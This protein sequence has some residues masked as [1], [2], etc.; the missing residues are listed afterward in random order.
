[1]RFLKIVAIAAGIVMAGQ[2]PALAQRAQNG[3]VIVMDYERVLTT[4]VAGRDVE[5]KL[6]QIAEQMQA[7]LQP[8]QTAV[9]T[10]AQALQTATRG[11]T[12]EQIQR[13]SSLNQRVQ[14]F[15]TRAEAFR[16]QQVTRARDLEYT[17]QQALIEFNRQVEPIVMEVMNARRAGVVVDRSSVQIMAEGVDATADIISRLDQRVRTINVTR[18]SAPAPQQQQPAAPAAN[19]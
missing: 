10:E 2:T 15:N 9:Q 1:M 7:E 6:R 8:E 12:P 19:R 4:S 17:R 3:S 14:A 11:Q 16:A 5:A 13:N 18:Q